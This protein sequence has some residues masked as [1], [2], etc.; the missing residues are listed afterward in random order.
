[1]TQVIGPLQCKSKLMERGHSAALRKAAEL[2]RRGC[3]VV[4]LHK[5]LLP[6]PLIHS[7]TEQFHKAGCGHNHRT[8]RGPGDASHDLR[9]PAPARTRPCNRDRGITFALR[10]RTR[11]PKRRVPLNQP[12]RALNW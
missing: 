12:E 8:P 10:A 4:P 1:M 5:E 6:R 2:E 9:R 3:A 7:A 11:R